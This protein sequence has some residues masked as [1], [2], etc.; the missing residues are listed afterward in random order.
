MLRAESIIRKPAVKAELVADTV[1]LDHE[2]R[3]LLALKLHCENGL[4]AGFAGDKPANLRDG[5]AFKLEDGRL[6]LVR[7]A[8]EEL[9][10]VTAENP[11]RLVRLAWQLGSNHVAMEATVDALY[12]ESDLLLE[13]LIRGQGCI[14]APVIRPF[15]P[16]NAVEHGHCGCGHD[17]GHDHGH[18]H[19]H[20]HHEHGHEHHSHGEGGCGCGCGGHGH[21]HDH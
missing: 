5:D 20:H 19:G 13:E 11:L 6:I 12:V 7:A 4:I 14:L 21:K 17:H 9:V 15:N 2:A 16:E 3:G 1:I 8:N 10:K 18:E